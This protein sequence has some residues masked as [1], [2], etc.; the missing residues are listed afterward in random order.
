MTTPG[1]QQADSRPPDLQGRG[2]LG[3]AILTYGMGEAALRALGLITLPLYSR[4]LGPHAYGEYVL[5]LGL[6]GLAS[7]VFILGGDSALARL[8]FTASND[9]ERHALAGAWLRFH[10][11]LSVLGAAAIAVASPWLATAI[12]GTDQAWPL[13]ALAGLCLPPAILNALASQILRNQFRA[14]A[15]IT[16]NL[17]QAGCTV[18]LGSVAVWALAWGPG[19]LLAALLVASTLALGLRASLVSACW[20]SP[21][22]RSLLRPLLAYGLPLVPVSI[23][24][25]IGSTAD[26]LLLKQWAPLAEIGWYGVAFGLFSGVHGLLSGAFAQAWSPHITAIHEQDRERAAA[27]AAS[28]AWHLTALTVP[29]AVALA[30]F[31][32]WIVQ[33]ISGPS[34]APAAEVLPPLAFALL[35]LVTSQV[36]GL[37]ITFASRT[38]WFAA[39]SWL[40]AGGTI[41]ID[42]LLIPRWGM[43]G[44]AWAFCLGAWFTTTAYAWVS[45]RY[46][47]VPY[48][49]VR[50]AATMLL[51]GLAIVAGQACGQALG[52]T[53]PALLVAGGLVA[54]SAVPLAL[55]WRQRVARRKAGAPP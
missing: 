40:A 3:R 2:G 55:T 17:L 35:A 12:F 4:L 16:V 36:T 30:V 7:A 47:Q 31:A 50:I 21:G 26:R 37:G 48:E 5:A 54:V 11:L 22:E 8:W 46:W 42:L 25:W 19:G 32:P 13:V 44:C 34:Y 1:D 51:G 14:R 10:A 52:H 43:L 24:M 39:I 45:R 53:A 29:V 15:L 33:L 28:A 41:A 18:L 38:G 49:R 20:R 6:L 23:A 27:L 9:G